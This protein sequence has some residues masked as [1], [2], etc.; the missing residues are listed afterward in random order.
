MKLHGIALFYPGRLIEMEI[1]I[2]GGIPVD[3]IIVEYVQNNRQNQRLH[4]L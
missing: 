3:A 4:V 1:H 2:K